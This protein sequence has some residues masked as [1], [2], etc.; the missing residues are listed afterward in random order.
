MIISNIP[1][2]IDAT[3]PNLAKFIFSDSFSSLRAIYLPIITNG[4][5]ATKELEANK[6]V[7]VNSSNIYN[8]K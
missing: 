3:R 8:I 7:L 2:R 6:K 4:I 5:A 1:I